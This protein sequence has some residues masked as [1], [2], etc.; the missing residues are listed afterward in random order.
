MLGHE[1]IHAA[2]FNKARYGAYRDLIEIREKECNK[3]PFCYLSNI[4]VQVDI[5]HFGFLSAG[6]VEG[7]AVSAK[8]PLAD[9]LEGIP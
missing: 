9:L 8:K 2:Q 5:P 3:D 4:G 6:T 7:I 1:T